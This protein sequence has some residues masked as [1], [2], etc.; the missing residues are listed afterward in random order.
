M[1]SGANDYWDNTKDPAQLIEMVRLN[2]SGVTLEPI[3][4]GFEFPV[5]QF[6]GRHPKILEIFQL[7]M[8]IK[9][10]DSN[11]LITGESGT[12]KEIVARAI[13]DLSPRKKLPWV[14]V[15]CGAIPPTL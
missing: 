3:D 4:S 10:T 11:V 7:I 2:L 13:H 15:N 8:S 14:A 12:G 5:A 1:K 6:V 9:D